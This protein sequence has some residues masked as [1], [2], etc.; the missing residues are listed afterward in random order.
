M[1]FS[2]TDIIMKHKMTEEC[3]ISL[4]NMIKI[5][6]LHIEKHSQNHIKVDTESCSEKDVLKT[7]DRIIFYVTL[8]AV[9]LQL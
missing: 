4:Y 8:W 2:F 7:S 6:F 3:K 9:D 1:F 5:F